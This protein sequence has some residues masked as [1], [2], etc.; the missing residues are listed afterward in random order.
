MI[1]SS[2]IP[3]AQNRRL[4]VTTFDRNV[5]VVAGAGTGK[6]TLLVNRFVHTLMRGHVP[7][8][9]TQ[10]VALTF[11]NKA[12]AE[13][14]VRLREQLTVLA[15][16]DCQIDEKRSSGIINVEDLRRD[17]QLSLDQ[18]A[19]RARGA[20]FDLE[21]AQIGTVHSFAAHL[22]RLN[23]IESGVDPLFEEDDGSQFER[24]FNQEWDFW[25]DRELGPHGSRHDSWRHIL[26][27][28]TLS[29][30]REVAWVLC[31][32]IV[33]LDELRIQVDTNQVPK[34]VKEWLNSQHDRITALLAQYEGGRKRK[35]EK[36]LA[37]AG[38]VIQAM[39]VR[40]P[41]RLAE[42]KDRAI[43]D[44]EVQLGQ[45]PSGWNENHFS[46]ARRLILLAKA[47]VSTDQELSGLLL[48]VLLPFVR[49]VR[50]SFH[51]EGMVAFDGLLAR[52]N[53]LLRDHQVVRERLKSE[54]KAILVDEFQDTDPLQYEIILY[55]AEKMGSCNLGWKNVELAPG[56][57]FIVGDPKQSIYAFRRADLEAYDK[58]VQ[59]IQDAG[60]VILELSTNFRSHETILEVVNDIFDR[61]L[62]PVPNVQPGNVCLIAQPNRTGEVTK[63]GVE[64][65]V[66]K[67]RRDSE[68]SCDSAAATRLEA[69][70]L[71][72]WIKKDLLRGVQVIDENGLCV[73]L[74]PGHI[75]FLL[76]KLTHAQ[77]Y[78]DALRR[79]DIPYV[80]DGE[81]HFYRRQE[82]IDLI[83]L[84]R[85]IENP[86]DTIALIGLLRSPL[87]G[88]TDREI[89]H[90]REHEGLDYR[91]TDA[92]QNWK[93]P[94]LEATKRLYEVLTDLNRLVF[95]QSFPV[96]IDMVFSRLP[97]L[98]LAMASNHREQA[99]ANL[100]KFRDL[101]QQIA[102][103]PHLSFNG[104]V[105]LLIE[106]MTEER[107]E[108]EGGLG[109][110]SLEA[111]RV[112]TV[113]KAKGLEFPVVILPGLH[114]GTSLGIGGAQVMNDWATGTMGMSL[115][116]R[117]TVGSVLIREKLR[118]KEE[119]EQRR[120]LYVAM[121][122]AKDRLILS[123]GHP[124]RLP[125]GSFL[126]ILGEALQTPIGIREQSEIQI[127]Y[128][129]LSQTVV[130]QM[131]PIVGKKPK[132]LSHK[133]ENPPD[134][135]EIW[136]QWDDR[137]RRWALEK[138]TNKF[139]T[140]T[141]LLESDK[142]QEVFVTNGLP[143]R[144]HGRL[145]GTLAH[146]ILEEWDFTKDFGQIH[147]L[148]RKLIQST[149]GQ[150]FSGPEG[151]LQKE[152]L[153]IFEVF[154]ASSIYQTLKV[155]TIV[156]R[157][158][159]FVIPWDCS[160]ASNQDINQNQQTSLSV[161]EG[162]IDLVYRLNGCW[163]VADYKTDRVKKGI[164][165]HL[166]SQHTRQAQIYK[167]AAAQ[168]LG[169]TH[170]RSQLIYIRQGISIEI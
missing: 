13:M 53:V 142:T 75:G 122:R 101:A 90:L 140:T 29:D 31:N 166:E 7:T 21:K 128:R 15:M 12:A 83:N 160:K 88:L 5:V 163:W 84:L 131:D 139:V 10:I 103:R 110:E 55:L 77:D 65:H 57:L 113:H 41:K 151:D 85:A 107:E 137:E 18:V 61:V 121:T 132:S 76:R 149:F 141:S 43:P 108:S 30:I 161:L 72:A 49:G 127:G 6:T 159:P 168:C 54:Y 87:G 37:I 119:A 136:K 170:I 70:Q 143:E 58:V 126:G 52:A 56:K 117:G 22:L 99:V 82:V 86:T 26:A 167:D 115:G 134:M 155:A 169:L 63:P 64:L 66:V 27:E 4:A 51:D 94:R 46:E 162:V 96:T 35:V 42:L 98:E 150:G 165:S 158:I 114:H 133:L 97:I 148:M 120:L 106:R 145:I 71:A 124:D 36:T 25:L 164:P 44:L 81:K 28:L 100:M 9:I 135:D 40:G 118:L 23:P 93:S 45:P 73:P 105:E 80:T 19:E 68:E 144:P 17:Y 39:V 147:S 129:V 91:K 109:E 11:T 130:H 123:S 154:Y 156:G 16:S 69:E 34:S 102:D 95:A 24:V 20:L 138:K 2:I 111:I 89:Y 125:P 79:Y 112:M 60:G 92:L 74:Q 50:E 59:K 153:E 33:D 78:L 62:H 67:M 116:K 32:E 38:E 1:D 8:P 157:E 14:K 152:L 3:D 47:L 104:F 146:G 48:Q